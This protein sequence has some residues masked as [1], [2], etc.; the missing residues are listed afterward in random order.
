MG[1]GMARPYRHVPVLLDE[2]ISALQL[3][4]G[5]VIVDCTFGLG[6]HAREL[7]R[8]VQ[9]GGRVIGIDFDPANVERAR[10]EAAAGLSVHH[11]NF[12]GNDRILAA[13]GVDRHRDSVAAN[14]QGSDD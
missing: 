4:A 7:L 13:E 11:G 2:V 5:Q 12:A 1:D 10:T 9:P 14:R 6:G 8:C 3:R